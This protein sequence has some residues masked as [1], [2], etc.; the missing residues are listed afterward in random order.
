MRHGTGNT[1]KL[2]PELLQVKIIKHKN[3][4][5][6]LTIKYR[7]DLTEVTKQGIMR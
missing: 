4:T 6:T 2:K 1:E 7:E 3:G 5:I